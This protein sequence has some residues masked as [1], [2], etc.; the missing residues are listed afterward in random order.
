MSYWR[1]IQQDVQ[2]SAGNTSAVNLAGGATFDGTGESS[3]GVAGIQVILKTD[4]NCAVYVDQSADGGL[5][6]DIIDQYD[7]YAAAGGESWTTQAV[8]DYFRVRITNLS[9]SVATTYFRLGTALCPIIEALPRR[10]SHD[11]LLQVEVADLLGTFGQHTK[12]S[13]MG[14]L[15]TVPTF[16][17][18]GATFIGTTFDTRFWTKTTQVALGD[19][20]QANGMLI[21]ATNATANGS[22]IVN[23]VRS[24]RFIGGI[25]NKYRGMIQL[26]AVTG[27]NVRRWG[28]FDA[29][30]GFYFK[31][32]G[33][34]L[35]VCSRKT[36]G[37]TPV[38]S[39]S[40]NGRHGDIYTLDTDM[41]IFE[42]YWTVQKVWFLID[43][44]IIHTMTGATTTLADT[45]SLQVG[46]ECTNSGGNIN[47]NTMQ[48]RV[49]VIQRVGELNHSPAWFNLTSAATTVLKYGPGVLQRI[50]IN[51]P[52]G[53]ATDT[54]IIYD[55]TTNSAPIIGTVQVGRGNTAATSGTN[56]G[57]I[58]FGLPFFTGLTIVTNST[59]DL[60][61]VYE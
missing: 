59:A 48:I 32:D 52:S 9:A 42:I 20:T 57:A 19:A 36:T 45:P 54:A 51:R 56:V 18:V 12:S 37:E 60:T 39:G 15:M 30:N 58:E 50:V 40:F 41:H 5:N 23:S 11:G 61:I 38:A 17:L 31:H 13:P 10:L 33:T 1:K 49:A 53:T 24:A 43:D 21:L 6:W 46:M 8:G 29:N 47:N 28:A 7:Y 55:N 25:P 35:S 16:N 34:T 14:Q 27:T 3:L 2:I 44:V 22:I 4:Q 26:P